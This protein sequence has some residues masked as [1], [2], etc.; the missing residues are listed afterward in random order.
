MLDDVG[1]IVGIISGA[2]VILMVIIGIAKSG[3]NV[4]GKINKIENIEKGTNAL[5]LIHRDEL[6]ALYKDQIKI[7]F[8][9]ASSLYS[10]EEKELL[11]EKLKRGYLKHEE[12]QK[13]TEILKYRE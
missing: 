2:I 3:F 13:L 6:F 9:P 5:L 11:L 1:A 7:V 4:F 12:A 8:N 10:Q